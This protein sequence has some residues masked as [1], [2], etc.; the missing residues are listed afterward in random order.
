MKKRRRLKTLFAGI[1]LTAVLAVP[2]VIMAGSPEPTLSF[3][4]VELN[5]MGDGSVQMLFTVYVSDVRYCDGAKF[6]LEYN[7]AYL[8]PSDYDS[9][10]ALVEQDENQGIVKTDA[11]FEVSPDLY[12]EEGVPKNPFDTMTDKNFI[13]LDSNKNYVSMMLTLLTPSDGLKEGGRLELISIGESMGD[14]R[15]VFNTLSNKV[16]LGT[17]SFQVKDLSILPQLIERFQNIKGTEDPTVTVDGKTDHLL[18]FSWKPTTQGEGPW[19]I[20]AYIGS[21]TTALRHAVFDPLTKK[22]ETINSYPAKATFTFDFP[23]TI[24]GVAAAESS[25]TL[26]AYRAYTNGDVGDVALAMQKYSPS[27]IATY[28]DGSQKTFILPWKD[29]TVEGA[30]APTGGDYIIEQRFQYEQGGETVT[31]PRPITAKL[32]VTPITLKAVTADDLYRV[33]PLE[34]A[35]VDPSLGGGAKTVQSAAQFRLPSQARLVTDVPAGGASLTVPVPG[36][37][38]TNENS[39]WPSAAGENISTLRADESATVHWPTLADKGKWGTNADDYK[40]VYTFAMAENYGGAPTDFA[41]GDLQVAY[42]WLTVPEETYALAHATRRLVGGEEQISRESYLVEYLSTG[43][44]SDGSPELT[45]QVSRKDMETSLVTDMGPNAQFRV[46]LPD[47]TELGTGLTSS[48]TVGGD[49]SAANW[50]DDGGSY[51]SREFSLPGYLKRG[52]QL[53]TAPGDTRSGNYAA[54]RER[55]RRYINLGGWFYVSV[56]EDP[57]TYV[58]S[59]FIPVYVPPRENFHT[60]SKEYNFIGVNAGL[61]GWPG[62]LGTTVVLPQGSYQPVDGSGAPVYETVEGETVRKTE[63]YGVPTT[64]DGATGAE[65]GELNTFAVADGWAITSLPASVKQYGP[66]AFLDGAR[67][68]AYGTVNNPG[69]EADKKTATLR[70]E[71]EFPAAQTEKITLT[72]EGTGGVTYGGDGNVALVTYDTR[73]EGYTIRQDY[74]LTITNVGNTDLYGLDVDALTGGGHFLLLKPPAAFLPSGS[75][76]TFTLSYVYHLSFNGGVNGNYRDTL[77]ITSAGHR[78]VNGVEGGGYLLDFDAQFRV[79]A[80]DIHRVLVEVEPG[81]GSLGTAQVIIGERKDAGKW[82]MDTTAG[83]TTFLKDDMVYILASPKDEYR[84]TEPVV[85]VDGSGAVITLSKY[86][87]GD[88]SLA[89]E[90]PEG[91]LVYYFKMPDYDVTVT[92]KLYEPIESKLRLSEIKAFADTDMD[93]LK[94][95]EANPKEYTVWQKRFSEEE[96]AAAAAWAGNDSGKLAE[97]LMTIGTADKS[98]LTV[99]GVDATVT[100]YLVVIP[101][102][103]DYAQVEVQLRKVLGGLAD[104]DSMVSMYLYNASPV[105]NSV[106]EEPILNPETGSTATPTVHTSAAFLSPAPGASKYVRVDLAHK[107]GTVTTTRSYYLEIHRR[108]EEVIAT[109]HYGNSP[110]GMIMNDTAITN[111]TAAKKAFVD[112]GYSFRGL[113]AGVPR[114]VPEN[115]LKET[116][117]WTE[118][119]VDVDGHY[120]PEG[121]IGMELYDPGKNLD[122][123]DRAFFAILTQSFQDPGIESVLDSSG[124]PA[125]ISAA[126]IAVKA[127]TLTADEA[128]SDRFAGPDPGDEAAVAARTI[129]LSLGGAGETVDS[130]WAAEHALRPGLYELEY[131]LADYDGTRTLTVT[132][133]FVILAPVGDVNGDGAVTTGADSDET[134]VKGR[135]TAPLGYTAEHY[136]AAAIFKFRTC[137]VNNDRNINNIDANTIR[138]GAARVT[139]FYLPTGYK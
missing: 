75:S 126:T 14:R 15:L 42:P 105:G 72:Y 33:Y 134:A 56:N 10:A 20:G 109:L 63:R 92:V 41:R 59:D 11:F 44:D 50:F 102:E 8:I 117:Y 139:N 83:T 77:Y 80:E 68:G 130:G 104:I 103:A 54:E 94:P 39:H 120:D 93:K 65:P 136:A 17:L 101:Y 85:G 122:L 18:W 2:L 55:L 96:R 25:L 123:S 61:F 115:N 57:D 87:G 12:S 58:W 82:V 91:V 37:S 70:K 119:W 106:I 110:Y 78:D 84:V 34:D 31:F 62:D 29:C 26:D 9:N 133:P 52:Y 74:T 73:T 47:G 48:G 116:R 36:W 46:L 138:A 28:A 1:F 113:T 125:D 131:T 100:Q 32:T 137:D 132:R 95:D 88:G 90:L 124:R 121:G 16:A 40:G 71:G 19:Y 86:A 89:A 51:S 111:K 3:E 38:P 49:V 76:T 7:P 67:Y 108:P 99:P 118:A 129:A 30:Y 43:T 97:Y 114:A 6:E 53:S 13:Y 128:L 69:A 27:V 81:D 127:I 45:L 5:V 35:L 135:V 98:G 60:Q 107:E 64:Y 22:M 112:N 79:S 24:V 23:E 21:E 66:N 4:G